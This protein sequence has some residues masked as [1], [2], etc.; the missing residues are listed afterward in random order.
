MDLTVILPLASAKGQY[1]L[2]LTSNGRAVWSKIAVAHLNKGK[3]LI[4]VEVD[5]R[6]V[7]TGNYNLE[8]RS[9]AG[10]HFIQPVSLQPG[11]G[12]QRP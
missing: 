8:V 4:R 12:E 10:I 6:Q 3:T 1:D 11:G 9:P 7:P 5:F 2:R